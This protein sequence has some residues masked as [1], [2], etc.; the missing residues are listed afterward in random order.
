MGIS[1]RTVDELRKQGHD[2]IHLIESKGAI[3]TQ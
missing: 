2:A 1:P 3:E